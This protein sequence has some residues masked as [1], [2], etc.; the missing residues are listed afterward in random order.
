MQ[1]QS[2]IVMPMRDLG[3]HCEQCPPQNADFWGLYG[4]GE[5]DHAYAIGDFSTKSG[6]EFIKDALEAP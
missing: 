5:D 3:E 1:F 6:A 2:Y 4:I